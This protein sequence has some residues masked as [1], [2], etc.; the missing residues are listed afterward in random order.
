MSVYSLING[1]KMA[2]PKSEEKRKALLS[3]AKK[4]FAENGLSA[5]TASITKAAGMAE[6]TLFIYFKGKDDLMN[7]LYAEI[8]NDLAD[9]LL[10]GHLDTDTPEEGIRRVWNNFIDWGAENPDGLAVMHK[11]KVWVGL[12]PEVVDATLSRFAQL[13]SLIE[14]AISDGD[15]RDVPYEFMLA[16]FSAQA[17]TTLQ[18]IKQDQD[19]RELYKKSGF[20]LFWNGISAN[21]RSR[22]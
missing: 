17:E 11:L 22:Q 16:I 12:S 14:S 7:T 1:G 9:A 6:G 20:D 15:L 13:N 8:K 19:N 10:S 21:S 4:V 2:R 18:F 5:S 3:V